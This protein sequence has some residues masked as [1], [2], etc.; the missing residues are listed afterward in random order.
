MI[1]QQTCNVNLDDQGLQLH[2]AIFN[3]STLP[4]CDITC[5][6][7]HKDKIKKVTKECGCIG[8]WLFHSFWLRGIFAAF[9]FVILNV[10][11]LTFIEGLTRILW[12]S[13][14]PGSF[15]V[16]ATCDES[17]NT[18][19]KKKANS[20]LGKEACTVRNDQTLGASER[21]ITVTSTI[22]SQ[23]DLETFKFRMV[24][25]MMV[26]GSFSLNAIWV[27]IVFRTQDE[28]RLKWLY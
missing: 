16:W 13:L 12:E 4:T 18:I 5:S 1:A 26:F 28:I 7:P 6:G 14:H 25:L 19:T 22:K 23:L 15:T 17:G 11:R 10:S 24:G 27:L 20:N 8:E 9:I 3:C 2:D 21:S